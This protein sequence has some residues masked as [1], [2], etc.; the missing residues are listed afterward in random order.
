MLKT[1]V[2][3]GASGVAA[4]VLAGC[5][6]TEV[7]TPVPA[8]SAAPPA[9]IVANTSTPP[10]EV[11]NPPPSSGRVWRDGYWAFQNGQYVWIPAHWEP[12]TPN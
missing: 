2:I 7:V 11:R 6:T 1:T 3:L 5:G 10:V 9:V 8:Y 12:T 4:L